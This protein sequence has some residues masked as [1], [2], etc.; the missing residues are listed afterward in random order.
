MP[1]A[2]IGLFEEERAKK[3]RPVMEETIKDSPA[4]REFVQERGRYPTATEYKQLIQTRE[5]LKAPTPTVP[6]R[7]V[8]ARPTADAGDMGTRQIAGAAPRGGQAAAVGGTQAAIGGGGAGDIAGAGLAGYGL[9]TG[10]PYA[11]AAGLGLQVI[12]A[13][14][15]RRSQERKEAKRLEYEAKLERI[16]RQQKALDRLVSIGQGMKNL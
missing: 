4:V 8:A 13:G 11:L 14:A 1:H 15:R 5:A 9:A 10:S 12:G 6:R 2:D 16:S 7:D 3:K